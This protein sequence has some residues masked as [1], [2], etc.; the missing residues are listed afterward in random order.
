MKTNRAGRDL[1]K[2]FES[3]QP[4]AYAAPEQ[5]GTTGRTIGYGHVI[6]DGDNIPDPM[7][8]AE[9]DEL[10]Q[11]DLERFERAVW[12]A[13]DGRVQPIITLNE[14]SA[15]V[16]FV[17]NAGSEA[18]RNSTLRRK[19]N[20]L[21]FEGA[22]EEFGKWVYATVD[23]KKVK[24]KGLVDRRQAERELFETPDQAAA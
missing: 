19:V 1:I 4:S 2:R 8:E 11:K 6:L 3:F 22:A 21:D 10:L 20:A 15:L 23:G 24:L 12:K 13:L 9:A 7:T 5:V 17:F 14:F 18:F 16:S